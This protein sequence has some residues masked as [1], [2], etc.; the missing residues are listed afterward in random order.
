MNESLEAVTKLGLGIV[1]AVGVFY[2]FG[3]IVKW[4]LTVMTKKLDD[5]YSIIVKLIDRINQMDRHLLDLSGR[6]GVPRKEYNEEH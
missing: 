4:M 1:L 2:L 3:L 6:L 5:N